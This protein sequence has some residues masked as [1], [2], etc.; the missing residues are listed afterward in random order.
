MDPV[1]RKMLED[2]QQIDDAFHQGKVPEQL[3]IPPIREDNEIERRIQIEA[4][5]VD[6]AAA[7]NARGAWLCREI[8]V[9]RQ[10]LP[11]LSHYSALLGARWTLQANPL[12]PAPLMPA[13]QTASNHQERVPW[14]KSDN[15]EFFFTNVV[16]AVLDRHYGINHEEVNRRL[17]A[18]YYADDSDLVARWGY[19]WAEAVALDLHDW[20]G[21]EIANPA[22]LFGTLKRYKAMKGY[23]PLPT[24]GSFGP[25][26]LD[27]WA[28]LRLIQV[29]SAQADPHGMTQDGRRVSHHSLKRLTGE[30]D[31]AGNLH[32][33]GLQIRDLYMAVWLAVVDQLSITPLARNQTPHMT[34]I[35]LPDYKAIHARLPASLQAV[36]P[37]VLAP[38]VFQLLPTA[39]MGTWRAAMT[40]VERISGVARGDRQA[41]GHFSMG[42]QGRPVFE[43]EVPEIGATPS[44]LW[45]TTLLLLRVGPRYF[46]LEYEEE[47][48]ANRPSIMHLEIEPNGELLRLTDAQ[49]EKALHSLRTACVRS[50]MGLDWV[51]LMELEANPL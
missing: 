25:L 18:R 33:S 24:D 49:W 47:C 10:C 8:A 27:L 13:L 4:N 21:R 50:G 15:A 35:N 48:P 30:K 31:A 5:R 22:L 16:R 38:L 45:L 14:G 37:Y 36:T 46:S 17:P 7:K 51:G 20:L 26:R 2:A 28:N 19:F 32:Y 23:N 29:M 42:D 43:L 6:L 1:S 44:P 9:R 3:F 11:Q 12:D 34:S 40:G 41:S 39:P